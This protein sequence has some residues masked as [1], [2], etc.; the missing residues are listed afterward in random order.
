MLNAPC[1]DFHGDYECGP[2]KQASQTEK[3]IGI[4][5]AQGALQTKQSGQL[6]TGCSSTSTN[7]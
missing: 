7:I 1:T 5:A 3:N 2:I 4:L 6:I